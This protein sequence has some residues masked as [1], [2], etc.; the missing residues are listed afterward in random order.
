MKIVAIFQLNMLYLF[1]K[2]FLMRTIMFFIEFVTILLLFFLKPQ[3]V[4]DITRD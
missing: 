3:F 4:W 2:D 1:F